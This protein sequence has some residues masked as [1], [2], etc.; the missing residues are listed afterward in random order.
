MSDWQKRVT[1]DMSREDVVKGI[2]KINPV[3]R[4]K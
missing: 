3:M 1:V 4:V 2:L